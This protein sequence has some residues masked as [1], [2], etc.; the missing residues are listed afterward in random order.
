MRQIKIFHVDAFTDRAFGG[1]AAGVVP[2]ANGLTHDEMQKIARELNLSETA[3]V[4]PASSLKADICV[5]YFTPKNEID[6]CGHATVA[7][8]WI[9]A[10]EFGWAEKAEEIRLE[11]NIGIVPVKWDK[12]SGELKGV[13]M[14]QVSPKVKDIPVSPKVICRIAGIREE[15]LDYDYPIK[16]AYTGNWHLLIPVKTRSAVDEAEPALEE[17]ARFNRE[18]NAATTHLF[19]FDAGENEYKIYT[20]DFAPAVG[21]AE[22]PV[23]GS[24]NGALAGYLVLEGIL[25]LEAPHHFTIG[26]GHAIGRPGILEIKIEPGDKGP[27]IQVGG[28]AVPVIS[29]F[30]TLP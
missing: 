12:E 20:R 9:M 15:N 3:F 16:L 27:I 22:D 25:D 4:L 18:H 6:F 7:L 29:G 23:T 21:V 11:T 28:R 14:T 26:Q 8:S 24:A 30:L 19:T 5:R 2:D 1:N 10:T 13:T 17:L